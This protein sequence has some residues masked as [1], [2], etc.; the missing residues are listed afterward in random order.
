MK[1]GLTPRV[2]PSL[3]VTNSATAIGERAM[4]RTDKLQDLRPA[5]AAP[6]S[7]CTDRRQN[8]SDC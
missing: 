8:D 3:L 6:S 1:P 2:A 7:A 4:S 5:V